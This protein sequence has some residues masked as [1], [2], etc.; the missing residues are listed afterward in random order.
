MGEGGALEV[1]DE[2]Y[3]REDSPGEEIEEGGD[4]LIGVCVG[5]VGGGAGE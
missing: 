1:S 5:D 2:S 3:K 4:A